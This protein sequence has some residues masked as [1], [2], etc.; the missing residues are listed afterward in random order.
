MT[1]LVIVSSST[2]W[3]LPTLPGFDRQTDC[4]G[5]RDGVTFICGTAPED[6]PDL[7][8]RKLAELRRQL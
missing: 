5:V 2:F 4:G 3:D 8:A 7:M 1:T 6:D